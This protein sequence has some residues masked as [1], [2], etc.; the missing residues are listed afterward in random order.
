MHTHRAI[1]KIVR[2]GYRQTINC[3]ICITPIKVLGC[4]VTLLHSETSL[5]S[6]TQLHSETSLFFLIQLQQSNFHYIL[7]QPETL[8][9]PL[10]V[11]KCHVNL[12]SHPEI[13]LTPITKIPQFCLMSLYIKPKS[14][15]NLIKML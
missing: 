2:T 5:H 11:Q 8:F 1:A 13:Y 10:F 12:Y 14:H 7:S 4:I 9:F 15:M 6:E 3:K